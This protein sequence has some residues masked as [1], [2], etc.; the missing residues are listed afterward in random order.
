MIADQDTN[1]VYFSSLLK[2]LPSLQSFWRRLEKVLIK[3]NI[4]YGFIEGTRDVWCRDYMPIQVG[5]SE[6]VQFKY[7]PSYCNDERYRHLI[8]DADAIQLNHANI[9]QRTYSPFVLDGGNVVKSQNAAV[10][11][12]RIFKENEGNKD[13][14]VQHLKSSLRVENLYLLPEQPYDMTGHSDG[15]VRLLGDHTLLVADFQNE[16]VSWKAKYCKALQKTGLTIIDFPGVT[17]NLKNSSGDYTAIGCYIN[18]AW[19]GNIILFPQFGLPE[20]KEALREA[21]HLFK[22]CSV[23]PIASSDLAMEGGVLNCVT[24][25]IK[26]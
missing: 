3:S 13:A 23:M 20:D 5:L 25:N 7:Y 2:E 22:D 6:F 15:M 8:T 11:T 24:W 21:K 26:E 14:V 10:L 1:F 16:S 18:F 17:T 4:N 12:E 19:I 9:L